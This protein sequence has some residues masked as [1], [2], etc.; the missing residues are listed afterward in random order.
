M[1][2]QFRWRSTRRWRSPLG[3]FCLFTTLQMC[4]SKSNCIQSSTHSLSINSISLSNKQN[5]TTFTRTEKKTRRPRV[6]PPREDRRFGLFGVSCLAFDPHFSCSTCSVPDKNIESSA[7]CTQ[8]TIHHTLQRYLF[9]TIG[10]EDMAAVKSC[11]RRQ[12][13]AR[14]AATP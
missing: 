1:R 4:N 11:F 14:L 6:S 10:C 7:D 3:G 2:W 12:T 9:P 8:C 13:L 5:P